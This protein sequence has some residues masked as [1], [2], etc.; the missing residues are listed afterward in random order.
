MVLIKITSDGWMDQNQTN[1]KQQ[2]PVLIKMQLVTDLDILKLFYILDF[3]FFL[4]FF[5]L[6]IVIGI[7]S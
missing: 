2:K 7:C 3:F 5:L 4:P 1:I 6:T